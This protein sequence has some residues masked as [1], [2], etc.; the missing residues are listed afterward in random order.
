MFKLNNL[1][2]SS[3]LNLHYAAC[4]LFTVG[5]LSKLMLVKANNVAQRVLLWFQSPVVR[6]GWQYI[7]SS[8][9]CQKYSEVDSTYWSNLSMC[10][11][12]RW[13]VTSYLRGKTCTKMDLFPPRGEKSWVRRWWRCQLS[14]DQRT[15]RAYGK[16]QWKVSDY[17]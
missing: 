14:G 13:K 3:E 10:C 5:S 8:P 12:R 11:H 9:I 2:I 6:T 15:D 7:S 4:T 16:L 17:F 1:I